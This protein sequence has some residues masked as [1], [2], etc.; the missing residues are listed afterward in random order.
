MPSPVF[1][2]N[3]RMPA[4]RTIPPR[5]WSRFVTRV[6]Q[7]RRRPLLVNLRSLL[8]RIPFK[9]VDINCLYFLEYS[10]VPPPHASFLRGRVEVRSATLED[11]DGLVACKP[12]PRVFRQRFIANDTCAVAVLDGRIIGYQW[13]CTKPVYVEERYAYKIPVPSDTIYTYD[14]FI[15]PDHRL[16]GIW[17]KFHSVYLREMMQRL[18]RQRIV[19]MVDYGNRLA[20]NTHLR[21]GFKLFCRVFI[22][23]V[24]RKSFFITKAL[25]G[26]T[27]A[28][29]QWASVANGAGAPGH[30]LPASFPAPAARGTPRSEPPASWLSQQ[31]E[32]KLD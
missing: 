7:V 29:P 14:I 32:H 5:V 20:M 8:E 10:S 18:H 17:F 3:H 11:F 19:G 6:R 30:T 26:D 12:I 24:F 25:R 15:V 16:A 28:L 4:L 9:P 27:V 21:F 1:N 2:E 13:I 22:I 23:K 31:T